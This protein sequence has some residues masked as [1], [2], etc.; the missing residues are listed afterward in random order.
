MRRPAEASGTAEVGNPGLGRP[1]GHDSLLHRRNPTVKLGV[2]LVVTGALVAVLDPWTPL[3]L[4]LLAGPA[5]T[6]AGALPWRVVLRAQAAFTPFA[7][8]VFLVNAVTRPGDVLLTAGAL[9][10]TGAG[11][12]VGAS[13]AW[14]TVLVGTLSTAFVLTTDGARLMT[15]LHQHA[16]LGP[17][18]TF[19]VLAGYRMLEQLPERWTTIRQAQAARVPPGRRGRGRVR[20]AARAAFTLLVVTLRQ[21]QRM[22]VSMEL[23]AL[24]SGPRTVHRPVALGRAD[25]LFTAVV[26]G[27][28]AA[29]VAAS[30]GAGWLESFGA[31]SPP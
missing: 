12:A 17:Q 29:V 16:R 28:C 3:A 13:L 25:A 30:A 15:S 27:A 7:L 5:V 22:A 11:V 31:F 18:A 23:R 24:G 14:R 21:S 1:M 4:L 8:S 10:V 6:W 19:A 26:L 2:L 9:E 20:G